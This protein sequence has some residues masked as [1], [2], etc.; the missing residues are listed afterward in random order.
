MSYSKE[1]AVRLFEDWI[2]DNKRIFLKNKRD[3]W[4]ELDSWIKAGATTPDHKFLMKQRY[5]E[6]CVRL[7]ERIEKDFDALEQKKD[8]IADPIIFDRLIKELAEVRDLSYKEIEKIDLPA[9]MI[10]K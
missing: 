4:G 9:D 5:L 6:S 3:I 8:I 10:D 1:Q 7:I 2:E